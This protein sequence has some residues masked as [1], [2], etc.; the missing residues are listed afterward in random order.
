[1]PIIEYKGFE[2][3][4]SPYQL[5]DTGDWTVRV[6]IT[7]HHDIRGETLEKQVTASNTFKSKVEAER[8][9]IEYGKQVID[10]KHV[11]VSVND[12]L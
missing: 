8:H 3:K 1:M 6:T 11:T 10:G 9:S 4:A 12:F 7:K 5:R 2:V